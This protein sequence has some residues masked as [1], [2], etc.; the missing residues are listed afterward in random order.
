[1]E[2]SLH[3][4][5]TEPATYE[6]MTQFTFTRK[7]LSRIFSHVHCLF[8]SF[9]L[10]FSQAIKMSFEKE[11]L[12]NNLYHS[13]SGELSRSTVLLRGFFLFFFSTLCLNTAIVC[14]S[15]W[16]DGMME[17]GVGVGG[18]EGGCAHEHGWGMN[19]EKRFSHHSLR[20]KNK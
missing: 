6:I 9:F 2:G 7:Y 12:K 4:G 16:K 19:G 13:R 11:V 5:R 1:M 8:L 20:G 18:C 15:G 10:A 17:M 3:R 14:W